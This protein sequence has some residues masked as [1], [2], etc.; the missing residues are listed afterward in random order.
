MNSDI[1]LLTIAGI[2]CIA[3]A[4]AFGFYVGFKLGFDK[5]GKHH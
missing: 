5:E 3:I 2:L 1:V 4:Y